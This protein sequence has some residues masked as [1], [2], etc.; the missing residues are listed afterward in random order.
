[1]LFCLFLY[2]L[3]YIRLYAIE[4]AKR[5]PL[6]KAMAQIRRYMITR[7]PDFALLNVDL[8][9]KLN[10]KWEAHNGHIYRLSKT[11]GPYKVA[12]TACDEYNAY[13]T[14]IL[15]DAEEAFLVNMVKDKM[16]PSWIGMKKHKTT[17]KKKTKYY[18]VWTHSNTTVNK[19]YWHDSTTKPK[20]E[21]IYAKLQH[22]CDKRLECWIQ[23]GDDWGPSIC[24]RKPEDKWIN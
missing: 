9:Y 23:S 8:Q 17:Y 24:K 11:E 12:L 7:D 14:D 15:D 3:W 6:R 22:R 20:P 1:M 5:D 19:F 16:V 4:K 2:T 21:Q 18:W 10:R 13:L